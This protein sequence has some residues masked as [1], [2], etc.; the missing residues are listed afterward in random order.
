M[1]LPSDDLPVPRQSG[2]DAVGR[3]QHVPRC[4]QGASAVNLLSVHRA[5]AE[6][7]LTRLLVLEFRRRTAQGNWPADADEPGG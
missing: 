6:F 3:R 4:D 7:T 1:Q 5:N 2:L